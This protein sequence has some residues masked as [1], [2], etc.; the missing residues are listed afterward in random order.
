MLLADVIDGQIDHDLRRRTPLQRLLGCTGDEIAGDRAGR[1]GDLLD[2]I[3]RRQHR[4]DV[5][6]VA[7][8]ER[9]AAAHDHE[10]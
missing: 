10:K 6:Q 2:V 3:L 4:A 7:T 8:E 1:D 9:L 5:G